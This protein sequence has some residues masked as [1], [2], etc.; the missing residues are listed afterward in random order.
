[1]AGL[2]IN[3]NIMYYVPDTYPHHFNFAICFLNH[4][5]SKVNVS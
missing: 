2:N 3:S 1:M 5:I 4:E